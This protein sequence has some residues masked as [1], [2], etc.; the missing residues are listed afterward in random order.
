M[1]F[2]GGIE[3]FAPD[4]VGAECGAV[5]CLVLHTGVDTAGRDSS[6]SLSMIM[7]WNRSPSRRSRSRSPK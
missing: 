4:T 7:T 2:G 1:P 5:L 6:G 3:T